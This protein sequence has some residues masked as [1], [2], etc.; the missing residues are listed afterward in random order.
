LVTLVRF[1]LI[2]LLLSQSL[3]AY[4]F[5]D[6][7][8]VDGFAKGY[9]I[10][11]DNTG[12]ET[13]QKNPA[14]ITYVSKNEFSSTYT[15]YFDDLYQTYNLAYGTS[16]FN[17]LFFGVQLPTRVVSG[18]A[19]TQADD[20]NKGVQIGSYSDITAEGIFSLGFKLNDNVNVGSNIKYRQHR[21]NTSKGEK[22][23][24]DLGIQYNSSLYTL[25]MS[26]QEIG[27]TMEWNTSLSEVVPMVTNIGAALKPNN[28]F[29]FLL[30]TSVIKSDSV[31]NSGLNWKFHK[32]M[33][34]NAGIK[35]LFNSQRLSLGVNFLISGVCIDYAYAQNEY[36]GT[37][38]KV[39]VRVNVH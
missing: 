14:A 12:L 29:T 26:V 2:L 1:A 24:Y 3:L 25:G 5:E 10:T 16:L 11:A 8:L 13:A 21:F 37:I 28:E 34:I 35:D 27:S 7:M 36:L 19:Q 6:S 22:L 33:H 18:I 4:S 20:D 9:A 32:Q 39:G 31:F 17:K 30:D 23:G 15:S 38:H